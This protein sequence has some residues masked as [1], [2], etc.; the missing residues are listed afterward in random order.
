MH[1]ASAY[2]LATFLEDNI[3]QILHWWNADSEFETRG[4]RASELR[5][6]LRMKRGDNSVLIGRFRKTHA[7]DFKKRGISG[8]TILFLFKTIFRSVENRRKEDL[9]NVWKE[10]PSS[11]NTVSVPDYEQS[12]SDRIRGCALSSSLV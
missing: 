4:Y 6:M 5:F 3:P 2:E 1:L 9:E 11:R 8:L 10:K 12:L 7:L